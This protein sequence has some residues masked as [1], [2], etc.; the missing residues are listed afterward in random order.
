VTEP[1]IRL[2]DDNR[3]LEKEG[4][5]VKHVASVWQAP[6]L[7][8]LMV[9]AVVSTATA[10]TKIPAL[11]SQVPSGAEF[12]IDERLQPDR[13]ELLPLAGDVARPLFAVRNPDGNVEQ[14][15]ENQVIFR[16]ATGQDLETFLKR[17]DGRLLHTGSIPEPPEGIPA[18]RLRKLDVS[19]FVLVAVNPERIDD[20]QM[21]ADAA[22]LGIA[23]R[24]AVS[25]K[26]SIKLLALLMR[27]K[28][29]GLVAMP[30]MPFEPTF[31]EHPNGI[32]GFLDPE[33]N[34][35]PT[36]PEVC[37]STPQ[38][39]NVDLAWPHLRALNPQR[40]FLAVIDDGFALNGNGQRL[41]GN[42][43]LPITINR[44]NF[45]TDSNNVSGAGWGCVA[46][47]TPPGTCWHG[48]A[49]A[50]VATAI[51]NNNFGA[52]GT[53]GQTVQPFYFKVSGSLF[54]TARAMRTAIRWGAD[55]IN[56]SLGGECG[57]WCDT[58]GVFSGEGPEHD[59]AVSARVARVPVV[60]SA[61][62]AVLNLNDT[63]YAPCMLPDVICVGGLGLN[64]LNAAGA[65]DWGPGQG[66]NFG[67]AVD[68]WAPGTS[69]N[70]AP[71]PL[72][73]GA[74]WVATNNLSAFNGTS[75]A[76]P[77]V[78]GV[79]AMIKGVSPNIRVRDVRQA[80]VDTSNK[81]STDPKVSRYGS[82]DAY[83]V[84][85]AGSNERPVG[86][87]TSP[88]DNTNVWNTVNLRV[89]LCRICTT[90]FVSYWAR[91]D[92]DDGQGVADHFIRF[93]DPAQNF[94][95]TWD[96]S[97]IHPQQGVEVWA[98][99]ISNTCGC[100]TLTPRNT[101]GLNIETTPPYGR[102]V[103]P[104]AN[105]RH[106][107]RMRITA[108]VGDDHSGV[109]FASFW[110]EGP[111]GRITIQQRGTAA[112]GYSILWNTSSVL[113][114]TVMVGG[115]VVDLQGNRALLTPVL[116]VHIDHT[117]P[118]FE[119]VNP[120]PDPLNPIW[121]TA[122]G[123]TTVWAHADDPDEVAEIRFTVWYEGADGFYREHTIGTARNANVFDNF[124][125]SWDVSDIPDQV[126]RSLPRRL[127]VNAS[128]FDH[129]GN[130]SIRTGWVVGFDRGL[131]D[132]RIRSPFAGATFAGGVLNIDVEATDAQSV[133]NVVRDLTVT[134][135]YRDSGAPNATEH[136]LATLSDVTGWSGTLDLNPLADQTISIQ[137]EAYDEA[138]NR[139]FH[140]TNVIL[141]RSVPS[142]FGVSH[143]P[144]PFDANGTRTMAF[145]FTLTERVD[146]VRII[147]EDDRGD[148]VIELERTNVNT[149]P[150]VMT[151]NGTDKLGNLVPSGVYSYR[152]EV[153][154]RAGNVGLYPGGTFTVATD[155]TPPVVQV[156]AGPTPYSHRSGYPA[157]IRY[158]QDERA[159]IEIEI[160]DST[161]R[162]VRYLGAWQ[163]DAGFY[164][165]T[166]DGSDFQG[167]KVP[168]PATYTIRL[169][170]A[171]TASNTS[172]TT[173]TLDVVP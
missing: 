60:A 15:V 164:D 93:G 83:R 21:L 167:N 157:S 143:S 69:L 86:T 150:Q 22:K 165:R 61:G 172:V 1:K 135:R 105:S 96:I 97:G 54:E 138:G 23:G 53:G 27:S 100:T 136:V 121:I 101:I 129:A 155:T 122:T 127:Y 134:A 55:V 66:S 128:G 67:L 152:F 14:F 154:D 65:V 40:V 168:A 47:T 56:L 163:E 132:I 92:A 7:V 117:G 13:P 94:N 126:D 90:T 9:V 112:N 49:V 133:G 11:Q 139:N 85:Y 151:W 89:T 118:V 50:N 25:S 98:E 52:A 44:Y 6:V 36:F 107:D 82:I 79:V 20:S 37:N 144:A 33:T 70:V 26:T 63:Y 35:N 149:D 131:P 106:G 108:E 114:Q 30:D 88:A 18:D 145:S 39:T 104:L 87:V 115:E 109:D 161:G 64:T 77:F 173:T 62:N 17:Y 91:Y 123:G 116:P 42:V 46:G 51:A 153:R 78:A 102:I 28:L 12:V 137:A 32:G 5:I 110:A 103:E 159:R 169:G 34:C 48:T 158:H 160:L 125:V 29:E 141:D 171:D 43:D 71:L 73:N 111:G 119:M 146:L 4:S 68:I 81:S 24:F 3:I 10:Q 166:W 113:E 59:A 147:V 76:S 72:F 74:S 19:S 57:F 162:I 2:G 58:F 124:I 156:A 130:E 84:L 45:I 120:S 148:S 31:P 95:A 38:A 8:L 140:G 41:F 142:I 75:A 170:A 16:S 80:L 99:L